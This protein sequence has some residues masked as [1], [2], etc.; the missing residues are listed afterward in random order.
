MRLCAVKTFDPAHFVDHAYW[1]KI[2][3][4]SSLEPTKLLGSRN[5][6]LFGKNMVSI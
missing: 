4:E 6:V 2:V 1:R 3:K 5:F